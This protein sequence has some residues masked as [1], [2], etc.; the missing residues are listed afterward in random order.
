MSISRPRRSGRAFSVVLVFLLAPAA[1]IAGTYVVDTLADDNDGAGVNGTSLREAIDAANAAGGDDTITFSVSGT[2]TL[3]ADLPNITSNIAITGP[4]AS[5]LTIHGADAYRAFIVMGTTV[6]ISGLTVAHTRVVGGDGGATSASGGGGSGAMGAALFVNAGSVAVSSVTFTDNAVVGGAGGSGPGGSN[7]SGG[8]GGGF[9][10]T[11]PSDRDGAGGGFLGGA[12]GGVGAP[13]GEGAGGGGGSW[14]GDGAAGGF[15]GGGGGGGQNLFSNPS[16]DGGVGG[17]GGGGGGGG[18]GSG[19]PGGVG[20]SF[21]G[22]GASPPSGLAGG[23][24]GGA[25]LGGAIFAR[26]GTL[27]LNNCT[28][29]SNSATG[30]A[31]GIHDG[32]GSDGQ[33]KGGAI[34]IHTGATAFAAGLTHSGNYA[35]DDV[36]TTGDDDDVYGTLLTSPTVASITRFNAD[37][38]NGAQVSFSVAF[39]AAVTGVDASDFQLAASGIAGATIDAVSGSGSVYTVTVGAGAGS[40]TLGLNLVD[41]DSILDSGSTALGGPGAGNGSFTGAIYTLD[42]TAPVVTLTP[43]TTDIGTATTAVFTLNNSE[44]IYSYF[45]SMFQVNHSGT[46]HETITEEAL[47]LTSF[48]ITVEGIGGSG[49]FTFEVVAGAISDEAGNATSGAI[50]AA[51]TR[52]APASGDDSDP[53]N[54]N[55]NINDNSNDNDNSAGNDN[56][57]DNENGDAGVTPDDSV[58]SD[59]ASGDDTDATTNDVASEEESDDVIAGVTDALVDEPT[60]GCGAGVCGAVSLTQLVLLFV[61]IHGLRGRSRR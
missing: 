30:G 14:G 17:F 40:G 33:G 5:N 6:S 50:S 29:N 61:G 44:T 54:D 32:N 42:R 16:P 35:A 51:V 11:R 12:G 43:D 8:G 56:A 23:G 47:S 21:A 15:G 2:I 18:P 7:L 60:S 3:T 4:G 19:S 20:G 53:D 31:G 39:S 36:D 34:F 9:G 57:N 28:F 25:G 22:D 52:T 55:A 24:G 26:A 48:R 10:V 58:N 45:P 1:C 41:D 37:P 46:S 38:T 49:T 59:D 13:G 27:T